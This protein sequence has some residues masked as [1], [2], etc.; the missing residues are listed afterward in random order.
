MKNRLGAV[1]R[2]ATRHKTR[3]RRADAACAQAAQQRQQEA[4]YAAGSTCTWR[5][6]VRPD[7]NN[8]HISPARAAAALE[9]RTVVAWG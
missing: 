8:G 4:R 6:T 1:P 5:V 2:A 9:I 7:R 3:T